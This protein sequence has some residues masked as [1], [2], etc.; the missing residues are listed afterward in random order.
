M[1]PGRRESGEGRLSGAGIETEDRDE[2]GVL[3]L[4]SAH[5]TCLGNCVATGGGGRMGETGDTGEM[6]IGVKP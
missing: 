2:V 6:S 1:R 4:M 5:P 3:S